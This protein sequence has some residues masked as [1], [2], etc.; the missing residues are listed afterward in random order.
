MT[1][2]SKIDAWLVVVLAAAFLSAPLLIILKWHAPR[3]PPLSDGGMLII[4]VLA[5]A[6]PAALIAWIFTTT[7]YTVTETDL[8]VRSG[9]ISQTIPLAAITKIVSTHTVLSAPALS[10][11]RLEIQYGKYGT[12]VISPDDKSGFV[13]AIQ[14]RASG[15]VVEG[16]E[17]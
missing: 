11:D 7:E 2:K 17:P 4:A 8:L 10:L 13:R 9:P 12:C 3:H 5:V 6:V 15:V 1:F 16:V 14:S